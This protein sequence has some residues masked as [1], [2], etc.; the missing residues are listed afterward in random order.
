[1]KLRPSQHRSFARQGAKHN[2]MAVREDTFNSTANI[3]PARSMALANDRGRISVHGAR[4]PKQKH[5]NARQQD[6]E[7]SLEGEDRHEAVADLLHAILI[8]SDWCRDDLSWLKSKFPSV[9]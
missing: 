8:H 7:R 5:E 3:D 2:V 4:T 9:S 6:M 1:M